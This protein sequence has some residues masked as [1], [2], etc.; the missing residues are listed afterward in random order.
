MHQLGFGLLSRTDQAAIGSL[1]QPF[2]HTKG[3]TTFWQT[4]LR[5]ASRTFWPTRRMPSATSNE[6]DVALPSS[7]TLTTV[8]GR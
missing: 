5:T 3:E 2:L 1:L 7:R 4:M 6:I 8:P